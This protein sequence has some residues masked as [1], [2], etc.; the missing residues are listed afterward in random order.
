MNS[1]KRQAGP[2]D[3][4]ALLNSECSF[5]WGEAL[6]VSQRVRGLY[7][8]GEPYKGR[9]TRIFAWLGIPDKPRASRKRFPGIVLVHGG[10]GTAFSEWAELWAGRGYV[11][12]AMD[13]SGKGPNRSALADGGPDHRDEDKF[14]AI[15]SGLTDAWPYHAVSNV[16]RATNLLA[17]LPEV[18]FQ[19]L[20]I[21]GISW[22]GYLTC[23]VSSI[24]ERLRAAA[25]VYGCGY[26][27]HN[28]VWLK[29]L[30]ELPQAVR[31]AWIANYDPSNY[32]HL[33]KQPMLWLN[34]T[35]DFAYPLDSYQKSY[36]L[37][38]CERTLSVQAGL[39]H[40]QEIGAAPVEVARFMDHYLRGGQPLTKL[41]ETTL[42]NNT[43][44]AQLLNPGA[45]L[46]SAAL[47]YTLDTGPWKER[48]WQQTPAQLYA[49]HV[50][51]PRPGTESCVAYFSV[52]DALGA[53]T[54]SEH[55]VTT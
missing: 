37:P 39:G 12:I 49:T 29:N 28:S 31:E 24:D 23:I 17:N 14:E 41:G 45:N 48:V 51:A 46:K 32:L 25:P 55:M 22:G 5:S 21:T 44:S 16:I 13:L 9:S 4:D 20:G 27:H 36:R 19:R 7:Y 42:E 34:G 40:G 35:N 1:T 15:L 38:P 53:V 10:G 47:H 43:L 3:L 6:Q 2:W 52:T 54:T 26:L 50:A 33:R 8:T 18:D 30:A 11:C